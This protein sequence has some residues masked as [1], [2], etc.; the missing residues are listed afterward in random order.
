[1]FGPSPPLSNNT[2]LNFQYIPDHAGLPRNENVVS[3][4]KA[5]AS[6]PSDTIPCPPPMS[7]SNSVISSTTIGDVTSPT[8]I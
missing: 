4:A 1:M 6:L 5:G 2:T 7:L 3:L 8:P